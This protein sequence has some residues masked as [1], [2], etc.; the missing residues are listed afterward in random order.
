MSLQKLFAAPTWAN[1]KKMMKS[2]DESTINDVYKKYREIEKQNKVLDDEK[3]KT[4]ESTLDLQKEITKVK[5][6]GQITGL[7]DDAQALLAQTYHSEKQENEEENK[8]LK[9]LYNELTYEDNTQ[10]LQI[11][12]KKQIL[13]QIFNKF[14]LRHKSKY[15]ETSIYERLNL[16]SKSGTNFILSYDECM[17]DD[18]IYGFLH[19]FDDHLIYESVILPDQIKRIYYKDIDKILKSD[20]FGED[21]GFVIFT[22]DDKKFGVFGFEN[23]D[24]TLDKC[25]IRRL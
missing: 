1:Q 15:P 18:F 19:L 22:N 4:I 14:V 10:T 24:N 20:K 25:L 17:N 12:E 3:Q 13:N 2:T 21:N 11:Q 23:R 7:S 8:K 6:S 5:K 9:E 16:E